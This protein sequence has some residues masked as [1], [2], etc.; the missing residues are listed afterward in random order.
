MY[1]WSDK[2]ILLMKKRS[3][4]YRIGLLSS[5]AMMVI[6]LG[7]PAEMVKNEHTT[8]TGLLGE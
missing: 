5:R 8:G 2:K 6:F 4:L 3:L 1:S 7:I